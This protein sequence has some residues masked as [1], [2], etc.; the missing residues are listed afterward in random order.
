MSE[1]CEE[2]QVECDKIEAVVETWGKTTIEDHFDKHTTW[3]AKYEAARALLKGNY[4]MQN[5]LSLSYI[6]TKKM[7]EAKCEELE[8][9]YDTLNMQ[10]QLCHQREERLFKLLLEAKG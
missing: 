9:R 7:L 5:S 1:A 3:K 8:K 4:E 10:W 6:H 2:V